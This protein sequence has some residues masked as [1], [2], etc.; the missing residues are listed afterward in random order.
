MR[1]A[2][3]MVLLCLFAVTHA[4]ADTYPIYNLT[5]GTVTTSADT[6]QYST[7]FFSFSG[8]GAS[9]TG[10]VGVQTNGFGFA[11]GGNT[12]DPSLLLSNTGIPL[13]MVGSLNGGPALWMFLGG[14]QISGS[15]FL[16]PNNP[17]LSTFSITLP[18]LFSGSFV[19]CE[20]VNALDGCF[21]S[22][23]NTVNPI[24]AGFTINGA[25]LATLN[26][27]NI[28]GTPGQSIWQL[29]N[30]TYTLTSAPEPATLLLFGTG[31][32]GLWARYKRQ[33]KS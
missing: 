11:P 29:S 9:L 32:I 4:A 6:T 31:A 18:V 8:P 21:N 3:L 5:S 1:L 14:I 16:L 2:G 26:F 13:P 23:T 7:N 24:V 25:G 19:G 27:T 22:A 33:R 30:G 20:F 12:L 10:W 17:S 15:P 28:S